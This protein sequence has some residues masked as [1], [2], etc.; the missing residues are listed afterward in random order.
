MENVL[1]NQ[2]PQKMKICAWKLLTGGLPTNQL[3]YR[4]HLEHVDIC[5][6]CG[7]EAE[8]VFH[9]VVS[10]LAARDVWSAMRDI[11]SLPSEEEILN[12][13]HEWLFDTLVKISEDERMK[14]L[15]II[16]RNWSLR[17][18]VTYGKQPAPVEA[19]RN[20]LASYASSLVQLEHKDGRDA[21]KGKSVADLEL[22]RKVKAV[23]EMEYRRTE[24]S[25]PPAG[26]VAMSVDGRLALAMLVQV[27]VQFFG[28]QRVTTLR[29][30]A[31]S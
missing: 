31:N 2:I 7:K 20:F 23:K 14:V 15:M 26:W 10:G 22:P 9:A 27:Q 5:K 1:E 21:V 30:A 29:H 4:R 6:R 25:P 28:I 12:T 19:T 24:W 17:N 11:W 18:D 3:K 13:G 8:D 16:W